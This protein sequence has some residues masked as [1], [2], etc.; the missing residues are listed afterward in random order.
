[1]KLPTRFLV[2]ALLALALVVVAQPA[3]AAQT[4]TVKVAADTTAPGSPVDIGAFPTTKTASDQFT[5]FWENPTDPSDIEAAW[6]KL[7]S[8]PTS[9]SDGTRVADVTD[10][11]TPTIGLIPA[12][13]TGGRTTRTLYLWLEDGAANLDYTTNVSVTLRPEGTTDKIIRVAGNDRYETAVATSKKIF[14]VN[15]TADAVLLANGTSTA[16]ALAGVPL[17]FTAN[18]PILLIK[19]GEIPSAVYA[20]LQRVLPAA[21]RVY[22]LGGT[23]VINQAQEDFLVNAGYNVKRLAGANR[24]ITSVQIMDELDLLRGTNPDHIY[25]VNGF[26]PADALSIAPLAAYLQDGIALTESGDLTQVVRDY[27]NTHL[28]SLTSVTLIGGTAVLPS[29]ISTL[30]SSA[31]YTVDRIGGVNRYDTSRLIADKYVDD[32]PLAP[33]GVAIASGTALADALPAGV[34][35]AAQL[36]PM[37]L[38]PKDVTSAT[39]GRT[40]DFLQDY[41]S[42]IQGGYLYGGDAVVTGTSESLMEQMIDGSLNFGCPV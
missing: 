6:Y 37:L 33:P 22:I 18:G 40:V 12:L 42:R 15:Q 34:H 27:A 2:S 25:L 29:S 31:G 3:A 10:P 1:M 36:Y 14:P 19:A 11:S 21:G 28:S 26:A 38:V 41:A 5:I 17:G 23:A 4:K 8:A 24:M 16:D 13:T 32:V 30:F 20:E 9:N 35:A 39:C 7:D